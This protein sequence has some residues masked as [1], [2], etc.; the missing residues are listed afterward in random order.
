[1]RVYKS[2]YWMGQGRGSG[3]HCQMEPTGRGGCVEGGGMGHFIR[4]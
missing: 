3:A 1:M 4:G 2:G